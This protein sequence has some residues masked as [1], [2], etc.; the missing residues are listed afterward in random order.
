MIIGTCGCG[1]TTLGE[2]LTSKLQIS[3][4]ELDDLFWLPSWK[5]RPHQIF[6]QSIEKVTQKNAWIIC[7]NYSKSRPLI[8][9]KADT[10]IWLDLPL[11]IL[12]IRILKRGLLQ[13]QTKE[14]ICNGNRQTLSKFLWML[15]W[16]LKTFYR[17]RRVYSRLIKQRS[18]L[19]W[20]H[21]KSP[22]EVERFYTN[23]D[24]FLET[25]QS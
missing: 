10:I 6:T 2:H 3:L 4:T 11:H 13:M 22:E 18:H 7:G 9:P 21:L 1:K 15:Y 16:V 20:I 23:P 14:I 25:A 5:K 12:F 17:R 24:V 8:W 19:H